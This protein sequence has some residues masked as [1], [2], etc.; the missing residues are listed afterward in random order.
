M[1]WP[2]AVR[3]ERLALSWRRLSPVRMHTIKCGGSVSGA[4]EE[5]CV[6][7]TCAR[8]GAMYSSGRKSAFSPF[9][10]QTFP[11]YTSKCPRSLRR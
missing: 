6:C 8:E 2:R 3:D 9:L 11:L 1:R 10:I 5:C 4:C 7:G